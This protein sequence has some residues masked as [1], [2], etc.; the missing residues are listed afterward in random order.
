MYFIKKIL[1]VISCSL[2]L[3][4]SAQ[5]KFTGYF[6]PSFA[7]NYEVTTNYSHNF[8]L[9][10]RT[11]FFNEEAYVFKAR[12]LDFSHFSNLK[13]SGKKSMS[14]GI[15][16]RFRTNFEP[17]KENELRLIQQ[18]NFTTKTSI[19]RFGHRFRSEQRIQPSLTIFRFRYRFAMDLPL[20][21]EKLDLGEAYL[22]ASTESLL[23]AS[24]A[25]KPS[26]DQRFSTQLGFKLSEAYKLQMG[27]EYRTEN[28]NNHLEQ[29]FFL[30]SAFILT[31]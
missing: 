1:I 28:F 19:I 6:E 17:D 15:Q 5:K 10:N 18:Y 13:V 22:I 11:Y 16:Y 9:T 30:N 3:Q 2:I 12:Q 21:G 27:I 26:Y 25:N 24:S 14:F 29:V 23:S 8:S 20:Q 4:V 31:L 7:L